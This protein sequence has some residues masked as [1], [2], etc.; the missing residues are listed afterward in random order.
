MDP[1]S[2]LNEA[3]RFL[4]KHNVNG[5][6]LFSSVTGSKAY[7][8]SGPESDTDYLGVYMFDT[9]TFLEIGHDLPTSPLNT[10]L[11]E[12][13]IEDFMLYEIQQYAKYLCEGNPFCV[14]AVFAKQFLY[15]NDIWDELYNIRST[16]INKLSV[17][18]FV[19]YSVNQLR[20][21]LNKKHLPGKRTY[22]IIRLLFEARRLANGSE[23]VVFFEEGE[24]RTTLATIRADEVSDERLSEMV[25]ELV[26]EIETILKENLIPDEPD[27]AMIND[28]LVRNRIKNFNENP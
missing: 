5:T 8:L 1:Q 13:E 14:E 4:S 26:N 9:Q 10:L 3:T 16:L 19:S 7:N 2:C 22:H 24:E 6:I 27:T 11:T 20:K 18:K 21:H 12:T 23:P 17:E 25:D 15:K 28:W